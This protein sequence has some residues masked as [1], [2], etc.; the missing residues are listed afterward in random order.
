M[1]EKGEGRGLELYGD[2]GAA[3]G[4]ALAMAQVEGHP[5]PAPVVYEEAPGHIR[6]IVGV[7]R[8]ARLLPVTR[9]RLP[10]DGARAVLPTHHVLGDVSGRERLDGAQDLGLLVAHG[11]RVESGGSL[12]RHERQQLHHMFLEHIAQRS[13]RVVVGAA[14]LH[15][16]AFGHRYLDMV[17]VAATP[18]WLPDAVGKAEDEYVL[19][20]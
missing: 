17:Y 20:R 1:L 10:E 4:E 15:S 18:D 12:H 13:R 2:L 9:H 6:F 19:H 3:L 16:Q 11:L 5:R 14:V 8:N 7:G